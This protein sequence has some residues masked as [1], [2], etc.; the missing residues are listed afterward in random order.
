MTLLDSISRA[1]AEA[2]AGQTP[3]PLSKFPIV[4]N[5]DDIFRQLKPDSEDPDGASVVKRV[6]GWKISETDAKI[7][8]LAASFV[9]TLRRKLKNTRSFD[10]GKFLELLNSFL[11]NNAEKICL[12]LG[13]DPL[14]A[15]GPDYTRAAIEKLGFLIGREVAALIAEGCVVL[16]V[17]EVLE[18]LILQGLVGHLNSI[19]LVEKLV[20]KRR[21][22]LLCL[23]V[24]HVPDFRSSEL[25]SVLK[26]F[27]SP[28]EESYGSMIRV[29]KQWEKQGLLAIEKAAQKG[30]AK[31]VSKLAKEASIL[32]M[33]AYD[34]FS[35][36]EICLH[37]LFG[38][39]NLDGLM[40]SSAISKLDGS[41]VLGL[42]RYF[43]KLLEK[44]QRFPEAGPCP[45]A[46]SVL[47]LKACES[48]PSLESV[49]RGLG[50]V[51][52]EH[53]LYLVLNSEFHD[54]MRAAEKVINSLALEADLCFPVDDIIK[55]LQLEV[56]RNEDL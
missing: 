43:V 46:G 39:S 25:L 9:K 22:E 49:L 26:Y 28:T 44:Y 13:S 51:L 55:Y 11:R 47:G 33:M 1:A 35:S 52:D 17:W 21:S 19:N 7:A 8:E 29:R 34:G 12:S 4:L 36:S 37:Y 45:S 32:L 54:E 2:E 42:I 15:S 38:S 31:K 24:K 48:V 27:L 50:L 30:I 53:F 6:S 16:E 56:R 18:S 23:F 40:L 3:S 14:D 10:Q 20:E 41:E 5:A